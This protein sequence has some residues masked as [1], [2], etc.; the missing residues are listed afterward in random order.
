MVSVTVHSK[1]SELSV[2]N[3]NSSPIDVALLSIGNKTTISR[4]YKAWADAWK[5]RR[6]WPHIWA[7]VNK[8]RPLTNNEPLS[9]LTI[10]PKLG[11]PKRIKTNEAQTKIVFNVK[12]ATGRTLEDLEKELT[13]LAAQINQV[14]KINLDYQTSTDSN[15]ALTFLL[16]E[17]LTQRNHQWEKV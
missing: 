3:R 8:H 13:A 9:P 10:S 12:P 7:T 11:L 17:Y 14:N 1:P 5:I 15:G 4:S 6:L 16:G 2:H